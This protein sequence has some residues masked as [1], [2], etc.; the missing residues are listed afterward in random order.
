MTGPG[1]LNMGDRMNVLL[2]V[3]EGAR[4][5]HGGVGTMPEVMPCL[6]RL[7]RQGVRCAR[8]YTTAVAALPA[9]AS[10]LSGLFACAHGATEES[11]ALPG[12]VPLLFETLRDAGYRTAAFVPAPRDGVPAVHPQTGCGRGFERF[13]TAR[14]SGRL[15]GAADYARRASDRVLG[16]RDA[17]ARRTT[18]ALR[19]WLREADEPF[20][21]LVTLREAVS[22]QPPP[23]PYDRQF[24][25]AAAPPRAAYAGALRY[26]DLRLQE[27]TDAL[28]ADGRWE[29]TLL[30]VTGTGGVA[31]ADEAAW[32]DATL[33]VPFVLRAPGHVPQ[34]FVVDE[35]TQLSDVLPTVL[36]LLGLPLAAPV[37]GRAVLR[38]GAVTAGPP[39]AV[40]EAYRRTPG[41][42]RRKAVCG[43]EGTFVWRSDEA[44][45]LFAADDVH[46]ARDRC[47]ADVASGDRQRRR[48]FAWLADAQSWARAHGLDGEVRAAAPAIAGAAGE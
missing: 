6:D 12:A 13:D 45:V 39:A 47:A 48:L 42:V 26:L 38:D 25:A 7:A 23:A 18:H 14:G 21:A 15:A 33:R 4:A 9:H 29:R 32:C 46:G 37:Q 3:L 17:G 2:V 43:A 11:G 35:I 19:H 24:A 5:D 8:A 34:G 44:N 10:L 28:A 1:G 27:I 31:F 30:L 36:A 16:R 22:P 40:A 20:G 41:D